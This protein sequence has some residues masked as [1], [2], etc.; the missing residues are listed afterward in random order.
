MIKKRIHIV[1]ANILIMGL[2]FKEN[3]PD[4]RNSRVVDLVNEFEEYNCNTDVYDPWVDKAKAEQEYGIKLISTPNIGKYDVTVLAV[5]HDQ[6]KELTL[7]EL[8]SYGKETHVI[9]DIKYLLPSD[10]TD[11]RL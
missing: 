6:F 1:D 10:Q 7:K 11:G 5:S 2:S 8:K 4:L 9:F 3:C